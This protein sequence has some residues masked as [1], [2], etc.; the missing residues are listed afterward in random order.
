MNIKQISKTGSTKSYMIYHEDPNVFHVNTLENHCYFIPFANGQD[1]FAERRK[2]K[3]FELLNGRWGFEYYSSVIDLPDNF[4]D[5]KYAGKVLESGKKIPVPSNWQLHGY[6]KPQYTNVDYPIPY[7]PPFVP[8]ENPTGVYYKTYNYK[9]DGL[10]RILCFEGADS[11]I[12]VYVNGKF[13]GFS[14][15]SHHT[16]EFNITPLLHEGQNIITVAVLKWCFGTYLE[17]QDKIR[18]S[19]IFR[20]VYVLSRPKKRISD[21]RIACR[22]CESAGRGNPWELELT[23]WGCDCNVTLCNPEGVL[24]YKG[25]AKKDETLKIKV[26]KPELWSAETP[27]L[28]KLTLT[29]ADEVIGEEV[30]FRNI[31]VENGVLKINGKAIKFR[32][33]NRHDSYPDTGYAASIEQLE[34]DLRLMKQHNIN[35]IRTS[36]YPNAPIF[37]KLCDKYGFYV[38]DEADLEMHGSVSVNNTAHWDWSDYSGIALVASNKLFYKGILDREK[39]CVTRDINRPCVIMWSM[40]NES[41]NGHNLTQA[42]KWIKDFDNTRLLH[43]ESLHNQGDTTDAPYDVVSRMYPSPES[44][45][46]FPDDKKEKRPFI[47]CEYCHAMGNGPGDLEDYHKVFHSSPRF[48]GGF[49]WEW[50]DHSLVMGK[51]KDGSI[52]YGYGGDWGEK[53][54]DSNF[55]CDGLTYPDRRP[56][57]GLLEA[58]QVYRPVRIACLGAPEPVEGHLAQSFTFWNLL[59]FTDASTVFDCKYEVCVDGKIV[60]AKKLALPALPPLKKTTVTVGGLPPFAGHDAYIRFI[61]TSKADTLWCKKGFEVCFDQVQLAAK[62]DADQ[63]AEVLK[64][65]SFMPM[66][67]GQKEWLPGKRDE[68]GIQENARAEIKKLI[69]F[70]QAAAKKND[71]RN[72]DGL[73]YKVTLGK[74]EYNFNRRTG[75]FDSIKADGKEILKKPL[76]FNFM[77][78]PTDNDPM[79][80][81]WFGAHLHDFET[82]VYG[83]RL[84]KS[85]DGKTVRITVDQGFVW[86]VHQPFMYGRVVYTIS[87]ASLSVKFNFIATRRIFILPRIGLRLF[88]D[89]GFNQ[90]EY[91]GYGPTESYI[92]KHQA[93]YVG[94]FTSKVSDQYEPYIKPQENSSHYGC[95]YVRIKNKEL[96]LICSG[97][98]PKTKNQKYISFNASQYTQEELWTRRHNYELQKSDY[99]VLCLDYMMA[100]VGSNSC[101]PALS[102]K[103]RIQLPDVTGQINICFII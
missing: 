35:A 59:A 72:G 22:H 23:V 49:I 30:G 4:A 38:I 15:V 55:C 43:Y 7:N 39:I 73:C 69:S 70:V 40:G 12:Y 54:N 34:N 101:G 33:T 36:H 47:L 89:K 97:T 2:S 42:A 29:T 48:C 46:K 28:Y 98:N 91:F 31:T 71:T 60:A 66:L 37:Y 64:K 80:N 90:I 94:T 1:A 56:H 76:S 84:E 103:Y 20:D 6:D 62:P 8:D 9:A 44:W 41:G 77:R 65:A 82:K 51:A 100:G 86:S 92:D 3:R 32:G 87:G 96:E 19:G 99:T 50:C 26:N 79:R 61:F 78:A 11:C 75:M 17:D 5:I 14:E 16:S 102:Q 18:L 63:E 24:I 45:S 52:K 53:H 13:C 81:E 93:T 25:P 88:L 85:A 67:K 10:E 27:V 58:K 68:K 74:M 83:S 95:R 57:T 21:Y